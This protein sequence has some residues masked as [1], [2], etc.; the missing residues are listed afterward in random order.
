MKGLEMH[1]DN[2]PEQDCEMAFEPSDLIEYGEASVRTQG[3]P[4]PAA[5]QDGAVYSS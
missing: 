2:D 4:G 1:P 3:G 5:V